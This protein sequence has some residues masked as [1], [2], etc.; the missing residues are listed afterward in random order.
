MTKH[1]IELRTDSELP[2][3][4]LFALYT[5]VGWGAYTNEERREDLH[6]AVENSS[7]VVSAWEGE[8]LVGL[9]R[10]LSD[11]VSIF[12]LQDILVHPEYQRR[13]IGEQLLQA[14]LDRYA[15]VRSKVLMTDDEVRQ[16]LFY[17]KAGFRNSKD[18]AGAK[19]N[20]FV[21]IDGVD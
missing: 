8:K 5:A 3:S 12:Y 19:L 6:K 21:L 20:T 18:L 1:G 2:V 15:H 17:E 4:S 14:C 7:Y 13:G 10:G 16:R 9:A 11:D